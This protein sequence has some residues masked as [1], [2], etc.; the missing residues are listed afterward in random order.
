MLSLT[1]ERVRTIRKKP[2]FD[3]L[4]IMSIAL[5]LVLL[6]LIL[7]L[8]KALDSRLKDGKPKDR[9]LHTESS[10]VQESS[11]ER[12]EAVKEESESSGEEQNESHE[13][14][15]YWE[16]EESQPYPNTEESSLV[17]E[18]EPSTLQEESS[19]IIDVHPE[20]DNISDSADPPT[21]FD[22]P[23]EE[24]SQESVSPVGNWGIPDWS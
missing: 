18:E 8:A 5:A 12:S 7:F 9:D 21:D 6:L 1:K 24:E 4:K 3:I 11:I 20:D 16:T 10:I 14:V 22:T 19:P 17:I 13:E 23:S 2:T 15:W